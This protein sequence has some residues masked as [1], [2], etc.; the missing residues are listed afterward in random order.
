M[1]ETSAFLGL[2]LSAFLAATLVPAQSELG[3]GYLVINTNYPMA[4]LVMVASLGNT[5]GAI[6]NWFIGQGIGK[7]VMHLEK[8][9]TS[10][11]YSTIII[12]YEKYG[13]WTLFLS[14]V[15]VIGDPITVISGIFN[16]PLKTFLPVVAL[17]KTS[18]Y[19]L[20]A[21]FAENFS[22]VT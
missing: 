21:I 4:L 7:S 17:A 18:R 8:I 20:I 13:L 5:T 6:I 9:K 19:I 2:F 12:W 3:L 22:L 15:P 1:N 10:P 11:R 16:V 14:W